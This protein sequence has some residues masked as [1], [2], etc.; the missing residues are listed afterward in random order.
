M[1]GCRGGEKGNNMR[2]RGTKGVTRYRHDMS[3][4]VLE[5][6]DNSLVALNSILLGGTDRQPPAV[7]TMDNINAAKGREKVSNELWSDGKRD[8]HGLQTVCDA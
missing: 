7:R 4:D 1:R 5:Q 3:Y 6:L 2:F 8:Q